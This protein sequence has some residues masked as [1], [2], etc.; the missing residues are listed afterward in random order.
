M[1]P[2]PLPSIPPSPSS[3]LR[4]VVDDAP[5]GRRDAAPLAVDAG[6]D[7]V[8]LALLLV[9]VALNLAVWAAVVAAVLVVVGL[10]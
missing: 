8:T 3:P 10:L 5:A 7:G 1:P 4:L 6:T 9:V 2:Q